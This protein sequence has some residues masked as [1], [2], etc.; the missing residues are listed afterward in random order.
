MCARQHMGTYTRLGSSMPCYFTKGQE[1]EVLAL[2]SCGGD[3]A[4]SG[5]TSPTLST[6]SWDCRG[7]AVRYGEGPQGRTA[8]KQCPVQTTNQSVLT[9]NR[10]RDG[11]QEWLWRRG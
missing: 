10:P 8:R 11:H 5:L 4:L 3:A 1:A 2:G 9:L 7:S 6:H